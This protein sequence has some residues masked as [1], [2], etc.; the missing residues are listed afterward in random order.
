[1][2]Q[3]FL[4]WPL[5]PALW[6]EGFSFVLFWDRVFLH[7]PGSFSLSYTNTLLHWLAHR[8]SQWR[9]WCPLGLPFFRWGNE[10]LSVFL[11]LSLVSYNSEIKRLLLQFRC[12]GDRFPST[13]V[14]VWITK[15]QIQKVASH[16]MISNH[17]ISDQSLFF[18]DM[19]F[20]VVHHY[21][22]SQTYLFSDLST[23]ITPWLFYW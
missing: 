15:I 9:K 22:Y 14:C 12:F 5:P 19:F 17:G 10:L 20:Y 1:M 4:H 11:R 13:T 8:L 2:R 21:H 3:I 7:G 23:W 16:L 6:S 18:P